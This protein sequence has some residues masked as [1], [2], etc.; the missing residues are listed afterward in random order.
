VFGPELYF[1]SRHQ[2]HRIMAKNTHIF[3]L[4]VERTQLLGYILQD[5]RRETCPCAALSTFMMNKVALRRVFHGE[6]RL[7]LASTVTQVSFSY[8][9]HFVV[10]ILTVSLYEPIWKK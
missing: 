2:L 4:A 9:R 10:Q 6:L 5:I 7:P 8:L 1:R 3:T